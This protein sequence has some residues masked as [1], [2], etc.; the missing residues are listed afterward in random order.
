VPKVVRL[1]SHV[2]LNLIFWQNKGHKELFPSKFVASSGDV[3]KKQQNRTN[4]Q[5][6]LTESG[7]IT[8]VD[9]K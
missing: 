5:G 1:F 2:K 3:N 4:K 7:D 6:K 8:L 9:W